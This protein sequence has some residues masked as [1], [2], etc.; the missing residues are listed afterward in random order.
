[1]TFFW[2]II[3]LVI[4][5]GLAWRFLGAYMVAVFEGRVHYLGFIE[6]P[7]YR[8]LGTGP[9]KEQTWKRYAG[10]LIVFSG[11]SILITYLI[12]RVQGSLPLNPQH[13]GAVPPA[14]S[15]NT[16]VS[17][18]TNTNW[19][20]YCGESTMSYFSQ[21]GA[22]TVQQF[23]SAA[24]GIAVAVA[25]IRGFARRAPRRSGTS[26]WTPSG[27][28]CTSSSRS[29]SSRG[30]SSW[31]RGRCRP[32][33]DP[34]IHNALN[35]VSQTIAVGPVGFMEAI[36]QLG[37][38]GGGL[39]GSG[40]G[41]MKRAGSLRTSSTESTKPCSAAP[42]PRSRGGWKRRLGSD[43][44]GPFVIVLLFAPLVCM[45]HGHGRWFVS[46]GPLVPCASVAPGTAWPY[47]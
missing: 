32:S 3:V 1:M 18:I 27:A 44:H 4:L 46:G 23:I 21:I 7:L 35:G 8:L 33:P 11:V 45:D 34:R 26:G 16:S 15:W 20:N 24:V 41:S 19:Q 12:I 42:R 9:D 28:V 36:K 22:L 37:T 2:T 40:R 29:P 30:S 14:L 39:V 25:L 31:P 13:L 43:S 5:L 10:A 47:G 17:F 6:R 38:N